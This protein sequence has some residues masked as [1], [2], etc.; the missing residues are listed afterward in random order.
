MIRLR[1]ILLCDYIYYL[2][3]LLVIIFTIFKVNINYKSNLDIN[4]KD[5]KGTITNIN[6]NGSKLN[7]IVKSKEKIKANYY[8]KTIREKEFVKNNIH[9]G[10]K[11]I[12]NGT[13]NKP[14][15]PK[16]KGLFNYRKYLQTKKIIYICKINQIKVIKQNNNIFY[17]LKEIIVNRCQNRYL[18]VFI[19][20]DKSQID[21]NILKRYQDLGISHLFAISGMHINLL[22]LILLKI[23]KII[24]IKEEKR[25]KIVSIVLLF[26]L[27]ITGLSA[28]VLRSVLFFI[29]FSINKINYLYIKNINIFI[30]VLSLSLLI[31]PYYIYDI[32]FLYS[33]SISG[34]LIIMSKYINKFNNYCIKLLVTSYISFIVSIPI[35]LYYF[36]QLNLLSIIYNIFYV[37]YVSFIVFPLALISFLIPKFTF[38]LELSITILESSVNIISKFDCLKLVFCNLNKFFYL[39]Y[40]I[41]IIYVLNNLLKNK[42]K[43]ILLLIVL[44]ICHYLKPIVFDK[45]YLLMIDIGQGDSILIHSKNKNMLIDTGGVAKYINK[46]FKEINNNSLALTTTIPLLKK[47]GIS[48]IDYL[49]I[50]HGDFD[51][52]GEAINLVNNFKVKNIYINDNKVNFLEK[53]LINEFKYTKKLKEK[54][55]IK[56]GNLY[57]M[58]LNHNLGNENDSSIVLYLKSKTKKLLLMGDASIK[59]E[60]VL[61]NNYNLDNID[62]LK[63][64]HHGSNTSTSKEFLETIKPKLALISAGV[65]NKFN[66]PHEETINR[67]KKHKII[68]KTTQELGSVKIY[69]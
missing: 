59:T 52:I 32:G 37:P 42:N 55:I 56:L 20:G 31:N 19:L 47:E 16:T 7:I 38:I 28:S 23:L 35:S 45:P 48:K 43:K 51:H 69:L 41:I 68:V 49:V 11:I 14:P 13:L 2:L 17:K 1:K 22:S 46:D 60:R 8:F 27:F 39:L 3:L 24:K 10:D 65:N 4:T 30:I 29:F 21:I 36:N 61:L 44:L 5:I 57:M 25:L 40:I 63:V 34:T 9:L 33:F 53:R 18:K 66:H 58:S 6:F 50:T 67:L 64:G 26:Y 12:I 62:I 15:I 54:E